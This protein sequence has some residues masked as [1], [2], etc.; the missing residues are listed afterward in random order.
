MRFVVSAATSLLLA[1]AMPASAEVFKCQ[2]AGGRIQFSDRPCGGLAEAESQRIEVQAPN[3]SSSVAPS[4]EALRRQAQDDRARDIRAVERDLE[5]FDELAAQL[6][7]KRFSSTA[8]RTLVIR[9]QVVVGMPKSAAAK[10]WGA[11]TRVNGWQ[12][13]YHWNK[14]GS[15][16]FYIENG[17]VSAVQ[18][19]YNG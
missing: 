8:L 7:C 1:V 6:P 4:E 12:W 10:A 17:C 2:G 9:N 13:A 11:P 16:F 3:I 15:S 19:E 5:R 18:G 14:G